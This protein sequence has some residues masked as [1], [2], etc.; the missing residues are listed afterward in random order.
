MLLAGAFLV[1]YL[2]FAFRTARLARLA[3]TSAERLFFKLVLRATW[4]SLALLALLGPAS[5]EMRKE[6]KT[7]GKDIYFLVDLSKSMDATDVP[8]SRLE[9]VKFEMKQLVNEFGTDRMGLIIFTSDA[10]LQC[11]LT[12][13]NSAMMLF[14]ETL[15]TGLVS[16]SGT[17]FYPALKMAL[18][19][20]ERMDSQSV[21]QTQSR[22][23]VLFSDGED[24][25]EQSA[26]IAETLQDRNIKLFTVGVGTTAG[27][28]IPV[29]YRFKRD[30]NGQEV[31]SRLEPA[32]LQQLA[33]STGGRYF[34]IS[35]DKNELPQLVNA[36]ER[37]EG[38]LRD[39]R[40]ID[41]SANRYFGFLLAALVLMLADLVFSVRVIRI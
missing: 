11:P 13:D 36:I 22:L 2:L 4:F 7:I 9:K 34:E 16:N 10:F 41:A 31:V 30:Q 19:K 24:F 15:N 20:F 28:R 5:G 38:D 29:G 39:T 18:E 25:G 33:S 37:I 1:L 12:Y 32:G 8:P 40:E 26:E 23:L 27:S 14:T 17:D 35:D 6:V 3:G 21:S